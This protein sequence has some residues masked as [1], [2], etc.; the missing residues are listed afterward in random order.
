MLENYRAAGCEVFFNG[1]RNMT[2]GEGCSDMWDQMNEAYNGLN[3]YD[4][5]RPGEGYTVAKT[6]EER[7]ETKTLFG[8]EVTGKRGF[9]FSEYTP[10]AKKH[11]AMQASREGKPEILL[12]DVLSDYLNDETV[13]TQFHVN[14]TEKPIY[15]E[16]CSGPV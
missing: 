8:K 9:T 1:V 5:F 16:Q 13:Q 3:W 6:V 2:G 15:W 11:P 4:L 12:G 7:M 10:W 14:N